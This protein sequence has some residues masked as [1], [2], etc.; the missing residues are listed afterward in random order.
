MLRL[1]TRLEFEVAMKSWFL[2]EVVTRGRRRRRD[3]EDSCDD[4]AAMAEEQVTLGGVLQQQ[5]CFHQV[6]A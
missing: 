5:P 2:G 1:L 3:D 6:C 4:D